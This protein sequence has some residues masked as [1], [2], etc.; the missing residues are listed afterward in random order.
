[1]GLA[2]LAGIAGAGYAAAPWLLAVYATRSLDGLVDVQQL[3]VESVGLSRVDIAAVRVSN[4]QL[5]LAARDA[6]VRFDPWPFRIRGVEVRTAELDIARLAGRSAGGG[7]AP[8]LPPIPLRV[9]QLTLQAPT[10]WGRLSVPMAIDSAPGP[11]GGLRATVDGP[12][13]KAVLRNPAANRHALEVS[14]GDD[15]TLLTLDA[16]TGGAFP[17]SFDGSLEPGPLTR[18]LQ[19]NRTVPAGL[20]TVIAPYAAS[21]T[22]VSVSGTVQENFDLSAAIRGDIVLRDERAP[23]A[24]RFAAVELRAQDGYTVSRSGTSWSGSGAATFSF[25]PDTEITLTGRDP[26]W[27]W[28]RQGATFSASAATLDP[29][30]LHAASI[31]ATVAGIETTAAEGEIRAEGFRPGGWPDTLGRYDLAGS[32]TWRNATVDASGTGNGAGLPAMSWAVRA[33]PDAGSMEINVQD[34]AAALAPALRP[35]AAV[36][37]PDLQILAGEVNGRYRSEWDAGGS[38][39]SLR[40]NAGSVDANLGDMELRGLSVEIAGLDG[41]IER[42]GATVSA[43]TLKLAAGTVAEDLDVQLRL[44]PPDIHLEQA[45]T[46]LFGGRISVR[47]VSF[48]LDDRE[49]VLFADIDSL[50]LPKLM[51]LLELE[52][53]ELTGQVAGPVRIVYRPDSGIEVNKGDLHSV[54]GGALRLRMNQ[55]SPMAAQLNNIALRALEDFQYDE[56]NASVLYK[57]DGEYRITARI[58]GR[59]PKV[60]DGHPI[61][62]NPTIEGRLPALFRAFFITGDFNEAII[63]RLQDERSGSTPGATP[64]LEG[65]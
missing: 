53:T 49:V 13:F 9:D 3:D 46:R 11:A 19:D 30:A 21:G 60:L 1:M 61:A 7:G 57:P 56:L 36:V 45:S 20:Q 14:D 37:A 8:G 26:A 18:W 63:Q 16:Q 65:D 12:E 25:A 50:S 62:L 38:T 23:P 22:T 51:A 32:W 33:G 10:P 27:T 54:R 39:V 58:L 47:P 17:W 6:V 24:R 42:L 40:A 28:S 55:G 41:G 29:L 48:R 59:N 44:A 2:L 52:T 43:P 64:T 35:Y 31:E 15:R 4:P 5:R 34:A